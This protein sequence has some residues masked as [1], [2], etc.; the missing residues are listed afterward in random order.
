[1]RDNARFF[2]NLQDFLGKEGME[3]PRWRQK[4]WLTVFWLSVME[5]W[6]TRRQVLAPLSRINQNTICDLP[7]LVFV[8]TNPP[9]PPLLRHAR[10]IQVGAYALVAKHVPE[11][12][13]M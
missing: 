13:E 10:G 3:C 2:D 9:A 4:P 8:L 5:A 12:F 1:M 7:F 11:T 6:A